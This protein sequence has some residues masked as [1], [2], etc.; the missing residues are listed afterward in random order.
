MCPQRTS[1]V[2]ASCKSALSWPTL[3]RHLSSLQRAAK[4]E[5]HETHSAPNFGSRLVP[6]IN[7]SRAG[8]DPHVRTRIP[9]PPL[10]TSSLAFFPPITHR[11]SP[12]CNS[13]LA[14]ETFTPE[15]AGGLRWAAEV[16][17]PRHE[18]MEGRRHCQSRSFSHLSF[19]RCRSAISPRRAGQRRISVRLGGPPPDIF[20]RPHLSGKW[21]R[22]KERRFVVATGGGRECRSRNHRRARASRSHRVD[23][24]RV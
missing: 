13:G 23:F 8:G 22:F 2:K 19:A 7:K 3:Q 15:K 16:K 5:R 11:I 17:S 21:A 6:Q 4:P 12:L 14:R 9:L 18:M 1:Q 20:N 24:E 10:T